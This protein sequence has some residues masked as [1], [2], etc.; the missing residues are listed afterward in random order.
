MI[1]EE[2]NV[3]RAPGWTRL[4]AEETEYTD[5]DGRCKRD[6]LSCGSSGHCLLRERD[7][8]NICYRTAI[9]IDSVHR[10]LVGHHYGQQNAATAENMYKEPAGAFG[11]PLPRS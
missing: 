3:A 7:A 4:H 5:E 2:I 9:V 6:D 8:E 11:E 1:P 10:S